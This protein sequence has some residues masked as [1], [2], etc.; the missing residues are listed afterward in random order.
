MTT[1]RDLNVAS[2]TAGNALSLTG[3]N[4]LALTA[5]RNINL[6]IGTASQ[7]NVSGEPLTPVQHFSQWW[8]TLRYINADVYHWDVNRWRSL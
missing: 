3:A 7:I 1:G 2:F 8:Y 4:G 5:A 6:S